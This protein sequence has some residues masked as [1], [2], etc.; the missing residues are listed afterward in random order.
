MLADTVESWRAAYGI[1][2]ANIFH[3]ISIFFIAEYLLRLI[4]AGAEHRSAWRAR[5]DWALSV[6]GI[7]DFL[8]T[9]PGALNIVFDTRDAILFGL[10]S[11]FKLVRFA[12]GLAGLQRAIGNARRIPLSVLLG[13][14]QEMRRHAFLRTWNIIAK[15]PFFQTIGVAPIAEVARL[16]RPRATLPERS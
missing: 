12:P 1:I 10:I 16:L 4:G 11:V 15:V 9:L 8:G 2:F 5:L 14:A 6:K 13:F 7:V 3:L